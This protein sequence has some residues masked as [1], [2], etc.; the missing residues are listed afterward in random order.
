MSKTYE[1]HSE[2]ERAIIFATC[3]E[4]EGILA[5]IS[6]EHKLKVIPAFL[7]EEMTDTIAVLKEQLSQLEEVNEALRSVAT[8]Q[9]TEL[10]CKTKVVYSGL[11]LCK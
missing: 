2:Q 5:G 1:Q 4:L 7:W 3:S 6:R 10:P 8:L 9:G 11:S